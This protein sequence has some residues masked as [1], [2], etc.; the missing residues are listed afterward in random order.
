MEQLL[1]N[2]IEKHIQLSESEKSLI[3]SFLT[4]K[5]IKKRD[6]FLQAGEVCTHTAFVLS[7]CLRAFLIDENGFERILQFAIEDWWMADMKSFISQ[8]P[9]NISIDAIENTHV[10]LLSNQDHL[11]LYQLCPKFERYSRIISERRIGSYQERVMESISLTA[12]ERYENF[13][14]RYP[15][16]IQRLPQNQIAAY[17]GITPEFLSKIRH[18]NMQKKY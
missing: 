14:K 18:Q 5:K 3:S 10:A 2:N 12:A 4:Y 7:G 11:E 6:Y 13:A 1:L 17:L 9:G 16:F 8:K 15:L